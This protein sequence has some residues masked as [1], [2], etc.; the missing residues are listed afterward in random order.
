MSDQSSASQPVSSPHV[1]GEGY[2]FDA[3]RKHL[4]GD[5]AT[6]HFVIHKG[7]TILGVCVG[8]MWHPLA[9]S[10]P[11]EIWVGK[12]EDLIPWGG[13]LADA[14]G[15][16]PIY[17]RREQGGKWFY[18]GRYEVTGSTTQLEELK[19]RVKPPTITAISRVVFMKR[20]K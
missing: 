4:G 13:K 16:I 1:V 12:K 3:I 5:Y 9:E 11:A 6:P 8:L 15:P 18:T 7:D 10:D 2:E 20:I 17:V 19:R 14:K